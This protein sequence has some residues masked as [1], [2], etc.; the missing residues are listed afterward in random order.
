[1]A[2]DGLRQQLWQRIRRAVTTMS[3]LPADH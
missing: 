3:S 1:V 2:E